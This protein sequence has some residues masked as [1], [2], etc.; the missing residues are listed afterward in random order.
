MARFFGLATASAG[1]LI[2][3]QSATGRNFGAGLFVCIM[4]LLGEKKVLGIFLLCW[5]CAGVADS[6]VLY[7]HPQGSAV[8]MH[9]RNV[10]VV[11]V[12]GPLLIVSS[13]L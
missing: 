8:G 13:L 4:T 9:V 1:E 7:E 3:F 2:L 11:W 6:K 10:F 12:L 5:S